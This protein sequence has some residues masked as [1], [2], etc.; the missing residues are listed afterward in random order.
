MFFSLTITRARR[1]YRMGYAV[2]VN[3]EGA[4]GFAVITGNHRQYFA[5]QRIG[6]FRHAI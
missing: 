1:P 3:G 2:K 5:R 6:K 4:K